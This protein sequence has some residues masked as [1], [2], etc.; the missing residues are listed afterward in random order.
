L[1]LGE[2]ASE[3]AFISSVLTRTDPDLLSDGAI[4]R[5]LKY[6]VIV[7]AEAVGGLLQHLVA[8]KAKTA[9][10]GLLDAVAKARSSGILDSHEAG[11]VTSF[12]RLRNM[13]VH[14]YWTIDDA[15]FIG[16]LRKGVGD[17][18]QVASAIRDAAFGPQ[19]DTVAP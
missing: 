1:L 17:F 7:V 4:V 14:H 10:S 9:V 16:E 15:R 2:M 8:R 5:S 13:L 3:A 18:Q 11:R 6:S 12:M 19:H